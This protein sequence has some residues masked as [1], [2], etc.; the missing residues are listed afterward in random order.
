MNP[1]EELVK[2]FQNLVAQV[3]EIVQPLIVF[4]A[5]A[6]PFVEGEGGAI[7]GIVGG[8]NP[9][10]AAIA[11]AAGNFLSVL[12]VVS[13]SS[14]A[15]TAAVSRRRAARAEVFAGGAGRANADSAGQE[16][17]LELEV[18]PTKPESKGRLR[19]KRWLVRFGVPGASILGPLAI[20]TQFTSAIL[21]A[22]GTPRAWVL[23]WQAIA[24]VLWTTVTAVSVWLALTFVVGV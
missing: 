5:G 1:V 7:I 24:I 22:S 14:R 8:I 16:L 23:L 3:P 18:S 11:A 10:I 9:I 4:V 2:N 15:R 19:F 17:E 21:V 20:P 13:L 12:L 6:V